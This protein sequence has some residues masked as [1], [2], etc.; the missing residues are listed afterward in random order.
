MLG[1]CLA[2]AQLVAFRVVRSSSEL[3]SS[4][5]RFVWEWNLVS[6]LKGETGAESTCEEPAKE[7]IWTEQR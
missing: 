7:D 6:D 4:N 5:K 3:V 1:N 2:I